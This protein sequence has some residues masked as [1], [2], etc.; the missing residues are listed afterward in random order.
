[1]EPTVHPAAVLDRGGVGGTDAETPQDADVCQGVR[2]NE[3]ADRRAGMEVELGWR[4]QKTVIAM[5]AGIKQEFPIYP[6]APAHMKWTP[7]AVKGL[8]YLVIDKGPQRQWLWEI[9]KSEERC[10]VLDSTE[11]CT[12]TVGC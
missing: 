5:L 3:E 6:A 11:R 7:V 10:C 2:G 1:M 8:V 12:P 4:L 9:G